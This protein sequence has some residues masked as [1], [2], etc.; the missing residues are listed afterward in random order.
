MV[1]PLMG[2]GVGRR[3]GKQD[4]RQARHRHQ[5]PPAP[6]GQA[7]QEAERE[8]NAGD[9]VGSGHLDAAEAHGWCVLQDLKL[10]AARRA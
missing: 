9:H 5:P 7:E 8:R 6:S 3:D 2:K 4:E 10:G 1:V